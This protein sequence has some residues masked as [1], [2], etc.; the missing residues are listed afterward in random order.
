AGRNSANP[1]GRDNYTPAGET[2]FF[3]A[4]D[5]MLTQPKVKVRFAG[6]DRG[7]VLTDIPLLLELSTNVPGF[8]YSGFTQ[9]SGYDL[10]IWNSNRTE[11]LN[12]EI[13]SWDTNGTSRVWVQVPEL[14]GSNSCIIL[15]WGLDTHTNQPAY[16]TNGATWANGYEGVWHLNGTHALDASPHRRHGTITGNVSAGV[17]RIGGGLVLA[18]TNSGIDIAGYFGLTGTAERTVS[19][20]IKPDSAP[21]E[22]AGWGSSWTVGIDSNGLATTATDNGFVQHGA[23]TLD[24][25]WHHLSSAWADDGTPDV[26]DTLIHVNGRSQPGSATVGAVDTM[27]GTPVR[28]GSHGSLDEIRISRVARSTNWTWAV[29]QNMASNRNFNQYSAIVDPGLVSGVTNHAVTNLTYESAELR[30]QLTGDV[31]EHTVFV[32]WG[33][34]DG[35]TNL[36]AWSNSALV[37]NLSQSSSDL[38]WLINGLLPSSTNYYTFRSVNCGSDIWAAPSRSVV[39]ESADGFSDL[40]IVKTSDPTSLVEGTNLTYTIMVSNL[41]PA[42]AGGIVVTDDLSAQTLF[43]SSVPPP[44]TLTN[45]QAI[46]HLPDLNPGLNTSIVITTFVDL[47]ATNTLT[48]MAWVSTTNQDLFPLNNTNAAFTLLP[49]SDADGDMDFVDA[50]DDNDGFT[51][52]EEAIANTDP[53]DAASYLWLNINLTTSGVHELSFPTSTGRLYSIEGATELASND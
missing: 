45:H 16:T 15:S 17:G 20:W 25:Q 29:F 47:G 2:M 14:G 21:G 23:N 35:G 1:K 36:S 48:N 27:A 19:A 44:D 32:Y 43:V 11:S 22:V 4:V 41:G 38:S 8:A 24:G 26:T 51:D 34:S 3:N 39:T 37:G 49:D 40:A 10:R 50:N 28:F 30:G 42:A 53:R 9:S 33:P 6:Y 5:F 46:Y 13:E 52:E 31:T 18:D 7:E 12:Y